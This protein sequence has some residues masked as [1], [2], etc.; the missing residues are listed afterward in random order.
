MRKIVFK[1]FIFIFKVIKYGVAD[2]DMVPWEQT[3]TPAQIAELS[4]YIVSSRG[5]TPE[6][7]KEAQ[8]VEVTYE[9]GSGST[10]AADTTANT[11]AE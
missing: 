9:A 2:K 5:T 4:N 8:G 1:I 6:N 11:P 7:P 10:A 3:L